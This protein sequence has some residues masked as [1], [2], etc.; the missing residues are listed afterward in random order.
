M[1]CLVFISWD[2]ILCYKVTHI[3]NGTKEQDPI[4]L[5]GVEIFNTVLSTSSTSLGRFFKDLYFTT[6]F[7]FDWLHR[8]PNRKI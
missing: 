6:Y 8:T 7:V 5:G 2:Y 1:K 3:N 4:G